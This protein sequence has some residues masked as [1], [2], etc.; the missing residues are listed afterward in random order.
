MGGAEVDEDTDGETGEADVGAELVVADGGHVD[1]A[2]EFDDD[3]VVDYD[4][5]TI[6]AG[7]VEVLVTEGY[8]DFLKGGDA[9]GVELGHEHCAVGALKETGTE[10]GMDGVAGVFYLLKQAVDFGGHDMLL[11]LSWKPWKPWIEK[12]ILGFQGFLGCLL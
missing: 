11:N 4:V 7:K 3:G 10:V 9:A 5:G 2:F 8:G 12:S 6:G 1:D